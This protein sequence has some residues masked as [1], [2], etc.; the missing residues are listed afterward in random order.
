MDASLGTRK[1]ASLHG[2]SSQRFTWEKKMQNRGLAGKLMAIVFF[3]GRIWFYW[4]GLS[5]T[6]DNQQLRAL[7]WNA[8][9]F[10]TTIKDSE[11]QEEHFAAPWQC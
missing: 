3:L 4:H 11:A 6:W 1:Q 8:Q 5:W 10:E 2:I 7:R 9:T